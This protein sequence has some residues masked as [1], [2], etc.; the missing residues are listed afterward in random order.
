LQSIRSHPATGDQEELNMTRQTHR[1]RTSLGLAATLGA[2]A[3]T[4]ASARPIDQYGYAPNATATTAS[5]GDVCSGPGYGPASAPATYPPTGARIP[6]DPRP[7][8]VAALSGL[9]STP[10]TVVR[11]VHVNDQSGF[12]WGDAG[13]GAGGM[14]A[15]TM[16]GLGGTL[17][18]S[19]RRSG[20]GRR[21]TAK[22]AQHS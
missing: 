15:L 13:I 1:I 5:C 19:T 7:R 12:D 6:H 18:A 2:I 4:P 8:A 22:E 14:L 10:A 21:P 17:V 20:L 16:I 11:V 9:A 3:A